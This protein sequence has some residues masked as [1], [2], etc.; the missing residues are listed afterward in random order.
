M[1]EAP[2][3]T[4]EDHLFIWNEDHTDVVAINLSDRESEKLEEIL[5]D[6]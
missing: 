1:K 4:T 3:E 6:E 2:I 5:K